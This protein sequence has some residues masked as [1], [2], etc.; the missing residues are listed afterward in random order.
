M[1]LCFVFNFPLM[2]CF[3]VFSTWTPRA[4]VDLYLAA[5]STLVILFSVHMRDF[6]TSPVEWGLI[7]YQDKILSFVKRIPFWPGRFTSQNNIQSVRE[8]ENKDGKTFGENSKANPVSLR[9]FCMC[10]TDSQMKRVHVTDLYFLPPVCFSFASHLLACILCLLCSCISFVHSVRS[11]LQPQG[12]A[13]AAFGQLWPGGC[14]GRGWC[15]VPP[16]VVQLLH[17]RWC[18]QPQ[19]SA[20]RPL[21]GACRWRRGRRWGLLRLVIQNKPCFQIRITEQPLKPTVIK[22]TVSV[23]VPGVHH[24]I[25]Q[26]FF[27][28]LL[29]LLQA[30]WQKHTSSRGILTKTE[31]WMTESVN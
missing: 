13:V 27:F 25:R 11:R 2:C 15:A 18:F 12:E 9:T 17:E 22:I 6:M 7:K 21:S 8:S 30:P 28:C 20:S 23:H 4:F 5:K 10:L 31:I 19:Q 26:P 16:R 29:S 1:I 24:K 14:W 3:C